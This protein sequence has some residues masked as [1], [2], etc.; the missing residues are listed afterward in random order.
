MTHGER[1]TTLVTHGERFTGILVALLKGVTACS[2][3][4]FEALNKALRRRVET[5]G[6][7]D[8]DVRRSPAPSRAPDPAPPWS[9]QDATLGRDRHDLDMGQRDDLTGAGTRVVSVAPSSCLPPAVR[10]RCRC[11]RPRRRPARTSPSSCSAT[12]TRPLVPAADHPHARGR[13]R[14]G[15]VQAVQPWSRLVHRRLQA[16]PSATDLLTLY[17][18]KH[19]LGG[20]VGYE[21]AETTDED[22]ERVA[23]IQRMSTAYLRT[24]LHVDG[25]AGPPPVP[26][27]VIAPE[28]SVA[29]TPSGSYRQIPL[30]PAGPR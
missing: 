1:F 6:S 27:S 25:T 15:P 9:P 10:S 8:E 29:S 13:G 5:T 11:E 16:Q 2:H 4:G 21:V 14:P 20:I 24:A 28:R 26:H 30:V 7:R 3:A 12:A 23:V 18:A 19:A 17:G 22:P